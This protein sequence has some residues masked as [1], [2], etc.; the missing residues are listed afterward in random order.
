MM[1]MGRKSEEIAGF[2]RFGSIE[3]Q[4]RNLHHKISHFNRRKGGIEKVN[5]FF[6]M[7]MANNDGEGF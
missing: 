4:S 5:N 7:Q 6:T 1:H 3:Q 2:F